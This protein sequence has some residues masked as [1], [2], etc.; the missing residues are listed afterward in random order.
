MKNI[1]LGLLTF[2]VSE[3]GLIPLSDLIEVSI[4]VSNEL[5][6]IT[7]EVGYEFYKDDKRFDTY[8]VKHNVKENFLGRILEY[9]YT[10]FKISYQM[11][12]IKNV[13]KW[14]FFIGGDTLVLPMLTAKLFRKKVILLFAGS[15][16]KTLESSNDNFYK[17]AKILSKINCEFADKIILYSERL[18]SEGGF[19]NYKKKITI[20]HNHFIDFDK[21]KIM[22]EISKRKNLVGYI[23]R[24]S[25]EK[26]VEEFL[27]SIPGLIRINSDLEFMI[28]G[29]GSLKNEI[30]EYIK[31]NNLNN[32]VKLVPWISYEEVPVYL[33]IFKLLVVPSFT[34]GLPNIMIEAMSCGTPILATKVGAIPDMIKDGFNGFLIGEKFT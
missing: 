18:I 29:D 6:L 20:A 19:E 22:T 21:F 32:N 28:C 11:L 27:N 23:G 13:D 12:K 7:G 33:N 31:K 15:S 30:R 17:I 2:P 34:E 9:V 24:L 10:Q 4:P 26:G 25:K 16:I 8:G 3:S 1:N 14:I 5:N